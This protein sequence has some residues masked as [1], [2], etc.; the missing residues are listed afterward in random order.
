MSA[1]QRRASPTGAPRSLTIVSGGHNHI[2]DYVAAI[3]EDANAAG[4]TPQKV[5]LRAKLQAMSKA[6]SVAEIAKRTLAERADLEVTTQVEM[7]G[8]RAAGPDRRDQPEMLITFEMKKR[9]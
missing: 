1:A 8:M 6:I 3:L 7:V 2:R 9:E 4:Q 5:T